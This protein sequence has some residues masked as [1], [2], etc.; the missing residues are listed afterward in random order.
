MRPLFFLF[1]LGS[2][3][4]IVS[5]LD[6]ARHLSECTK[7]CVGTG[8]KENGCPKVDWKCY[9]H[10]LHSISETASA[11]IDR[12]GCE[13]LGDLSEVGTLISEACHH[14]LTVEI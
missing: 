14:L 10:N 9:C 8:L 1:P 3:A 2:Y 5:L 11:C 7:N 13:D 4:A 6:L 12:K